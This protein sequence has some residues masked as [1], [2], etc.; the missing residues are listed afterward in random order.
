MYC[1]YASDMIRGSL[2][3]L[4]HYEGPEELLIAYHFNRWLQC[5]DHE[6]VEFVKP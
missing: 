1:N 4:G 3:Q 2:I 5:L 6:T